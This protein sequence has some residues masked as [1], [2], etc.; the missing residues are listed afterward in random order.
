MS[1]DLST[2]GISETNAV[3]QPML[4][5]LQANILKGHGRNFAHHIFI[6]LDHHKADQAKRWIKEFATM[7]ITSAFK[8]LDT[9]NAFKT[10]G[11]DGGPVFLLSLAASAYKKLGVPAASMPGDPS[12][13]AGMKASKDLLADEPGKWEAPFTDSVDMMIIAADDDH[14]KAARLAEEIIADVK[15]FA[16][17]VKEEKG[18][19]LRM[20]LPSGDDIVIEHFGYADGVSQPL[21]LLDDIAVQSGN[22]VWQDAEPLSLVLIPDPG[23]K[24]PDSF[25]S[26]FV[27][28]KLEQ[29]VLE[30]KKNEGDA[31]GGTGKDSPLPRIKDGTGANNDDLPG[32]MIVGRFENGTPVV[33]SNGQAATTITKEADLLPNDF[34]YRGDAHGSSSN[35]SKCPFHAHVRI[36]NPRADVGDFAHKVRVTRRGIPFDDV[37]RFGKGHEFD[38]IVSDKQLDDHRPEKGVG[39]LFM[40]YQADIGSQFEF[41][42]SL[43]VNQGDVNNK[44]VGQDGIIGQGPNT[45]PKTLPAQWGQASPANKMQFGGHVT[46][47]G[48]EYFF[49]PSIG[50]LK[51]L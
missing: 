51:A 7:K 29:N 3:F 10:S 47:K 20:T 40:C 27:F 2:K 16:T 50:F 42:Q 43:W 6:K 15:H 41:I 34:D 1:I 12:F 19:G 11:V 31:P 38:I 25:G 22:K 8:Q 17:E 26:Y 14:R 36:T 28:R 49:T 44:M 39:L 32:A 30:F 21:Y 45:T 48:G 13:Q 37:N 4:R 24:T 35:G 9:R 18:K 33:T 23:G 46:M 5:D